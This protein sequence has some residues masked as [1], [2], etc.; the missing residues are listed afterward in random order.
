MYDT[1]LGSVSVTTTL[2]ARSGPMLRA[3]SV[4]VAVELLSVPAFVRARSALGAGGGGGEQA[5][6]ADVSSERVDARFCA[7]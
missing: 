5:L 2:W 1:R 4:Q 3:W 7:S 6:V